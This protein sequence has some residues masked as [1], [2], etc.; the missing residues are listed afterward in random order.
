MLKSV[1]NVA[2]RNS[3]IAV[4]RAQAMLPGF[5]MSKATA[6]AHRIDALAAED[7]SMH[8]M[9][10]LVILLLRAIGVRDAGDVSRFSRA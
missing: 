4:G 1:N 9:A 6:L 10:A 5:E 3:L 8:V 2:I 7:Q